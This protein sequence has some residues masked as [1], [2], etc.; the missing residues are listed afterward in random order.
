MQPREYLGETLDDTTVAREVN[1][2][3]LVHRKNEEECRALFRIYRGNHDILRRP[4]GNRI[5]NNRVVLD[6]PLA[7]TR[8]ITGYTYSGGIRYVPTEDKYAEPVRLLK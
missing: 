4:R 5:V 7:F 2:A 1:E 3:L 8:N 6:Y